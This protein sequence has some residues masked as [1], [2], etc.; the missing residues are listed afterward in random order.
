MSYN[1]GKS[2]LR[3]CDL[4]KSRVFGLWKRNKIKPY[5]IQKRFKKQQKNLNFFEKNHPE[6]PH[7]KIYRTDDVNCEKTAKNLKTGEMCNEKISS[8]V[9]IADTRAFRAD[10]SCL[11]R[12]G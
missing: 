3:L 12:N 8:S 10:G 6:L 7:S 1:K 5:L 4:H 2:P 11:R 9:V